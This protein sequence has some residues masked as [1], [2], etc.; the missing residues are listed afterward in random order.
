MPKI[1]THQ[2]P[3]MEL[4]SSE[5]RRLWLAAISR[6]DLTEKKLQNDRVC[7]AHF[8]SGKAAFMW[9]R[10]N[11]D[12]VPSLNLG[13][14]KTA[15]LD[16]NKERQERAQRIRDRRKREQEREEKEAVERKLQ[17]I[18]ESGERMKDI[19]MDEEGVVEE[20]EEEGDIEEEIASGVSTQTDAIETRTCGTQT[21]QCDYMFRTQKP[22]M[23]EK[24]VDGDVEGEV[25]AVDLEGCDLL[26]TDCPFKCAN[27]QL[28]HN[29]VVFALFGKRL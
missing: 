9:D 13:H 14:N 25:E 12:W 20:V 7:G 2:G 3:E 16:D 24:S 10:M 18:D 5:R 26:L 21:E 8:K 19:E 23:P 1:I 29:H 28:L 27:L 17:K 22:W 11:V 4:L 6:E 15:K